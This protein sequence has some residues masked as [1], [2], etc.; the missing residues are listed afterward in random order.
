MGLFLAVIAAMVSFARNYTEIDLEERTI[1]EFNKLLFLDFG[2][3]KSLDNY[4]SLSILGTTIGY[5]VLS[6][7]QRSSS[8]KDKYYDVCLLNQTHRQRQVVKRCTSK[9][10]AL[11]E[12][13]ILSQKLDLPIEKFSPKLSS[14]TTQRSRRR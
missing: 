7:G 14:R 8:D 4:K 13:K 1:R 6:R 2:G 9:E 10:E 12:A 3:E 11:N 5:S